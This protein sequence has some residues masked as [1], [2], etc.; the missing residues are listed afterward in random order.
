[1]HIQYISTSVEVLCSFTCSHTKPKQ[2]IIFPTRWASITCGWLG[3]L[4]YNIFAS[5]VNK[6]CGEERRP[7]HTLFMLLDNHVRDGWWLSGERKHFIC[8]WL[9]YYFFLTELL[10]RTGRGLL[11]LTQ[12]ALQD[13][14]SRETGN[15]MNSYYF[16]TS[17]TLL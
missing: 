13:S 2:T 17:V 7:C 10:L 11:F 15:E 5:Q 6:K 3:H 16:S 8:D 9:F 12:S 1:M 14:K 4:Y